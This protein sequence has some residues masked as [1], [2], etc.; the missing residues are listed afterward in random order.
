MKSLTALASAAIPTETT[1]GIGI[2]SSAASDTQNGPA[3][4]LEKPT[5]SDQPASVADREF[6]LQL[7]QNEET[8]IS[9]RFQAGTTSEAAAE[10]LALAVASR[11]SIPLAAT[12]V[13]LLLDN[14][15]ASFPPFT[16]FPQSPATDQ[17]DSH[18]LL[19][20][21]PS[22]FNASPDE[23]PEIPG[24][25]DSAMQHPSSGKLLFG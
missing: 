8:S 9:R 13:P 19:P 18:L 2:P 4:L 16:K 24:T 22:P 10:D 5:D 17:P 11:T 3:Q 21:Q 14:E 15:P 7:I 12:D 20:L 23:Q 25:G 6:Q 1:A